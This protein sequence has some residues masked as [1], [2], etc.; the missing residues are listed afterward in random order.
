MGDYLDE[1]DM[2]RLQSMKRK[3]ERKRRE[4]EQELRRNLF[5]L[6]LAVICAVAVL[7]VFTVISSIVKGRHIKDT[8]EGILPQK[9]VQSLLAAKVKKEESEDAE[10]ETASVKEEEHSYKYA[11]TENTSE[12]TSQII[13]SHA[14][15]LDMEEQTVLACKDAM[16]RIVPASMTKVL[17]LLVAVENIDNFDDEFTITQEITEYC[18]VHG[19]SSAGYEKGET[20]T[21]RDLL[22]A[23]VLPSGADAALGLAHY[24]SGSQEAF[25]ELM[26]KKLEELGLSE[27]THFTNCVGIYEEDHYCTIYDMAMIMEA[28][29]QNET[30]LEVLSTRT[31]ITSKTEQHPEGIPLSNW[32]IR[33][34][35]DKDTAGLFVGGKTGYVE[36]SGS[37]A[38]SFGTD[39]NGKKYICVTTNADSKWGCIDDHAYMYA[40]FASK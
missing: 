24:V 29:L 40:H 4:R 26:N 14:I 7:G 32:F 17:T 11:M 3:Q 18:Y 23:T 39:E 8:K 16:S 21:V 22:Y 38:A 15:F 12:L 20:V 36:Q 5:K 33:R 31:Y 6:G 27:T 13:S 2:R 10:E 28:A 35:E 9:G 19:C 37:C 34:I 25:V 30:C 1:E